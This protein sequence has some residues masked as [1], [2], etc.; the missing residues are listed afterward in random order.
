GAGLLRRVRRPAAEARTA[1]GDRGVTVRCQTSV[2]LL[3]S[4]SFGM[5]GHDAEAGRREPVRRGGGRRLE[6]HRLPSLVE[7]AAPGAL[8]GRVLR[9]EDLVPAELEA[10]LL[11]RVA[12]AAHRQDA[13]PE[14]DPPLFAAGGPHRTALA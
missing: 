4:V 7:D 1:E 11:P 9:P 8:L 5:R 2:W 6:A 3:N 14:A 12:V 10:L 13:P